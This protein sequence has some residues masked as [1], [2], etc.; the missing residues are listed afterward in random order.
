M[1]D[2]VG[3][4]FVRPTCKSEVGFEHERNPDGQRDHVVAEEDDDGSE[5]LPPAASHDAHSATLQ[6][7]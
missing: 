5:G 6:V 7:K 4:G 1:P 3:L 2:N